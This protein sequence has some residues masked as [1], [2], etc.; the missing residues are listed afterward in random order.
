MNAPHERYLPPQSIEA[1][2]SVLGGLLLDNQAWDRIG[3]MI[4]GTDFYRDEHRRIFR[5]IVRMLDRG[6]PADAVTV[7][8][9]LDVAGESEHTGGLAYL[10][11]LANNT[12][13]AANIRR[14]AEI[15]RERRLRRDVLALGQRIIEL[16]QAAGSDSACLLEEVTGLAMGLA[17]TRHA[18]RE[19]QSIDE[20]LPGVLETLEQRTQ[21]RGQISGLPTGFR[22]LDQLTC[23]LHPGDL[24]IVAG[25]PSMGKTAFALNI[26]ENVALAGGCAFMISLEMGA[27]QLAERSMARFGSISTQALRSG[28]LGDEDYS[29]VS[30]SLARLS[31]KRLIVAD[32]PTLS[33]VARI[34][35]AARKVRQRHGGL[36]LIVIDYLQLMRGEGSTRNEEMSS[37]TRGLKLLAREL[38]CPIVLLSQLSRKVEE[39]TDKRPLMSDLR[40]SGAIEQ[41]ADVVLA[42]YRD[43]YYRPDSPFKGFAEILI[44]KQ[45][46]GPLGDVRLVFQGEFSRFCDADQR[47]F[48]EA[49]ARTAEA[50]AARSARKGFE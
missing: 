7:A 49:A 9:S 21:K 30:A 35:L 38:S 31:G 16:A 24:I 43:D 8:E 6:Q 50:R 3:D 22:D 15:V 23:G 28:D 2:Q 42:C 33:H 19:P 32:D 26:A 1:E 36:D 17:D 39:R 10:G 29:R 14:Y 37:V 40:D 34:R 48:A 4:A 5:H 18:G 11:E 27:G 46:M 12:P 25:R 41:D 47:E 45:R 20:L 44:R 13:S